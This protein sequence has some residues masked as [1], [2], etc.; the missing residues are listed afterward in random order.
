M[1]WGDGTTS[2]GTVSLVS[3]TTYQV[4]GTHT[5]AAGGM[6]ATAIDIQDENDGSQAC[7]SGRVNV[8]DSQ[9]G[10]E[11]EDRAVSPSLLPS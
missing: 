5:Y 6:L 11:S 1:H 8:R 3:G 10:G 7:A 4:T 2:S 9:G